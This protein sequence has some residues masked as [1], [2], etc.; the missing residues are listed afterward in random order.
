M[1]SYD[2]AGT[3]FPMTWQELVIWPYK[4]DITK[5]VPSIMY[6]T[7]MGKETGQTSH[8]LLSNLVIF[9]KQQ[10]DVSN[11]SSDTHPPNTITSPHPVYPAMTLFSGLLSYAFFILTGTIGFASCYL[12][13]RAIYGSVKID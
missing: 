4:Q 13:V 1:A 5:T 9:A 2:V 7:Y 8:R 11:S 12:F 10:Y 3:T 6:F